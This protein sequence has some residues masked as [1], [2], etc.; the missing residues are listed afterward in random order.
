MPRKK[1]SLAENGLVVVFGESYNDS[2]S[3]AH[4]ILA[5]RPD[6]RVRPMRSPTVLIHRDSDGRQN[7]RRNVD[8]IREAVR[9]LQVNDRVVAAVLHKDCDA[10]EPA[11]SDLAREIERQVRGTSYICIPA[12][13]A[14][15]IESWWYL[16]PD[17]VH[18][19]HPTWRK[20]RRAGTRVGLLENAKERLIRDLRPGNARTRD[21]VESDS[22]GI[23]EQVKRSGG[24]ASLA[25]RS[26]S[27][28]DFYR[29]LAAIDS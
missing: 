13:P 3:I 29:R 5:L 22:I 6:L 19:Y 24:A 2:Q 8:Q 15:E 17:S 21:Y 16:W 27:F 9:A 14:W 25:A 4:L 26:D 18:A 10:V 23:A 20:L 12:T 7:I 1:G 11:H 28:S